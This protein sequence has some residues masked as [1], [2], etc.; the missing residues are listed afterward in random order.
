MSRARQLTEK[1]KVNERPSK[2]GAKLLR[3]QGSVE[4]ALQKMEKELRNVPTGD[5]ED[6][7]Q[8]LQNIIDAVGDAM[9]AMDAKSLV[10][11]F[12]NLSDDP[13]EE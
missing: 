10:K 4:S 2:V 13:D 7:N 6:H 5:N 8:A 1:L 3:M 12:A 11:D 9:K